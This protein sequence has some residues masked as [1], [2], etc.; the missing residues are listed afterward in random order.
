M[1][2][3]IT[4]RLDQLEAEL[5]AHG[6]ALKVL[7]DTVASTTRNLQLAANNVGEWA[8]PLALTD[9]Q[10]GHIASRLQFL[11]QPMK[12]APPPSS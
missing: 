8:I 7:L 2:P 9:A 5:M 3:K 11:A 12:A 6:I 10:I 4:T 1:D